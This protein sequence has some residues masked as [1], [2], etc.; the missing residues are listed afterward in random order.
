MTLLKGKG[1]FGPH[2]TPSVDRFEQDSKAEQSMYVGRSES[3]YPL[4]WY[5]LVL[6]NYS[7][8]SIFRIFIQKILLVFSYYL[9]LSMT[10]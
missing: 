8:Y 5:L 3:F 2:G 1:G 4:V 10:K 7:E 9:T 6:V